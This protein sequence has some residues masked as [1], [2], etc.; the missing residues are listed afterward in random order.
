MAQTQNDFE[1]QMAVWR[2]EIAAIGTTNPLL[3]FEANSF[4]QIDLE[5]GHPGGLAQ[6]VSGGTTLLANLVRDPLAYSKALAAAK[7]IRLKTQ[8]LLDGFGV[9][10][11]YLVGGL[12]S[13]EAEGLDLSLPILM[14][15]VDLIPHGDDYAI[16]LAGQP[17]VNPALRDVFDSLYDVRIDQAKLLSKLQPGADLVPMAVFDYLADLGGDKAKLDLR[18]ILVLGTFCTAQTRMLQDSKKGSTELLQRIWVGQESGA[19]SLESPDISQ[20]QEVCDADTTQKQVVALAQAAKSFAVETLPGCGYTQT[21]VNLLAAQVAENR[22]VLVLA[23][24]RQTLNELSDRFAQIGLPGML[25][26][27]YSAWL[28]AISGISRNEKARPSNLA[29]IKTQLDETKQPLERYFASLTKFDESLGVSIAEILNHLAQLAAMQHAPVTSARIE[30]DKLVETKNSTTALELLNRAHELGEFKF[31]PQ[32]SA[33]FQAR[34]ESPSDVEQTLIIARRLKDETYPTLA[35]KLAEFISASEFKPARSI[36]DWATYLKLFVGIRE[37][38]DRFIPD[39][40]DRSLDDMVVATAAR[41]VK[42]EMSGRTRRRLKKLAKEYIRP[43][44]HVPDL[45]AGLIAIQQ[46]KAQW[47]SFSSGLKPPSVPSGIND[48]LVT[49]QALMADLE[50]IQNHLDPESNDRKL[51]ELELPELEAKL[52]SLCKDTGA[53]ENLGERADVARHLRDLG[54]EPLMRDLAKL[55]VY[56]EHIA[57]ELDLAWSQSALE[58]L[59]AKNPDASELN[60][61]QLRDLEHKFASLDSQRVELQAQEQTEFLAKSWAKLLSAHKSEGENLRELLKTG[62]AQLLQL[63]HAAPNLLSAVSPVLAMSPYELAENLPEGLQ[64]DLVVLLDAAGSTIAENLGGLLRAKQVVAF[65]DEAIAYPTGFEIEPKAKLSLGDTSTVSAYQQVQKAFGGI[66]LR[67]SYRPY[68][69]VLGSYINQEFYQNRL[70]FLPSSD[71]YF[72]KSHVNLELVT[73]G[74]RAS[75]NIDGATESLDAEVLKTVELIFTH[76]VWHSETSLLVATASE[77]HADRIRASVTKGLKSRPDLI[78]FFEGHGRE[79]FEVTTIR[80][81]GHR[82]ADRIIFSVGFGLTPH[83]AVLSNFGQLGTEDGRRALANLLVSARTQ[84]TV[85]SCFSESDLTADKTNSAAGYLREL[86][87]AAHRVE[88]AS[89][90]YETDPMLQD[91]AL[92]LRKLGATVKTGFGQDLPLIASYSNKAI[93]VEADWNLKGNDLT[94]QIRLR[95]ELLKSLGWNCLRVFSIELFSDPEQIARQIAT[96]LGIDVYRSK[97]ALFELADSE[98]TFKDPEVLGYSNS[99]DARLRADKPPHWG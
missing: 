90:D 94:E 48:A 61:E 67:R 60:A 99:N 26:K 33:W 3:N 96:S 5:R 12:A 42:G 38:L 7:K 28:D 19:N 39:V 18:R 89:N 47:Q 88:V 40:F 49:L 77:M 16:S 24:R 31:G 43:G 65:G 51:I 62:S 63:M 14:W 37:S 82:V 54:L 11:C 36:S 46:Q 64:F 6:F 83:G 87:A 8:Q 23:P 25:L 29:Q 22:R 85:V 58:A 1:S 21:V 55:H 27:P 10:A 53:L 35:A 17:M 71:D 72:G 13:F 78:E 2:A 59:L 44:M 68:G 41:K 93:V 32:D 69:Q 57:L 45:N 9:E 20:V 97:Q 73:E 30:S 86:L 74:N 98:S 52:V 75:S 66:T 70:E 34:F 4:A 84:I 92:R 79:R 81:L 15:P 95:P 56:R 80:E 91:L 76:A 50:V